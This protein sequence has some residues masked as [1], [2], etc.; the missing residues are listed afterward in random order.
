MFYLNEVLFIYLRVKRINIKTGN[1][2]LLKWSKLARK[3]Y[4]NRL[5]Y[6]I[7]RFYYQAIWLTLSKTKMTSLF[8]NKVVAMKQ[9]KKY[10]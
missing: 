7:G 4:K 5:F 9:T 3:S 10:I 8:H 6:E 1:S 2:S